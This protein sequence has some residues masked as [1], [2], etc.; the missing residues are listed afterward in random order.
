MCNVRLL[1]KTK[2]RDWNDYRHTCIASSYA[3]RLDVVV[4]FVVVIVRFSCRSLRCTFFCTPCIV[5]IFLLL[6]MQLLANLLKLHYASATFSMYIWPKIGYN[7]KSHRRALPFLFLC[8]NYLKSTFFFEFYSA[9]SWVCN[10][11][12]VSLNFITMKFF[13]P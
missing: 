4:V 13:H 6:S 2:K 9:P 11:K 1:C 8:M 3:L 10:V 5:H 7:K 12:E